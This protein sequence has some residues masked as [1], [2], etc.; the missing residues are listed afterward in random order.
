MLAS[1]DAVKDVFRG[2][3]QALHSGESNE[4][5]SAS[6]GTNS[7]LVLDDEPHARQRRVLL[8]PLKG[9]RMRSF[10]DVMQTT[11]LH[12]FRAWSPGQT[13]RMLEPMQ[14][15]TLRMMI[16]VVL[17]VTSSSQLAGFAIEV[18]G[19]LELAR[20]RYGLILVKVLPLELL[21]RTRWLP[22][23]QRMHE[24]DVALFA[25]PTNSNK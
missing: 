4:F 25:L 24:L 15:I 10:F 14:D 1:P 6:V 23:Y 3:P 17:G 7:V 5:L 12:T 11:T 8:P 22:F 2:D 9:E 18:R 21:Q 16:Q 19:V 20:G 13:L